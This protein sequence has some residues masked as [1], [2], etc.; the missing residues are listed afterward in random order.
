MAQVDA[1]GVVAVILTFGGGL[2]LIF[3]ERV[4]I[5]LVVGPLGFFFGFVE[6]RA[7]DRPFAQTVE[8]LLVVGHVLRVG[9][10]I[11]QRFL[12]EVHPRVGDGRLLG[13]SFRF[14]L[15]RSHR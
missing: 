14:V 9:V 11:V 5:F 12:L 7:Q 13:L 6:D 15:L 3:I 4:Q 10:R 1:D 2:P 8:G